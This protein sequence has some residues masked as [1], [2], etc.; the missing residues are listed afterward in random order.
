[1][2][3]TIAQLSSELKGRQ[4]LQYLAEYAELILHTDA[5]E[6]GTIYSERFKKGKI[7]N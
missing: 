2:K 4:T 7:D 5:I 1:M 3:K 6:D